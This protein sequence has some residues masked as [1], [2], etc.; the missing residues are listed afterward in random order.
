MNAKIEEFFFYIES[1]YLRISWHLKDG[2]SMMYIN[3]WN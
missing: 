3:K 1:F 2:S